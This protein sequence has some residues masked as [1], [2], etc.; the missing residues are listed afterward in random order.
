MDHAIE[1]AAYPVEVEVVEST[2]S[3]SEQIALIQHEAT[4]ENGLKTYY[5]MGLALRTIRDQRL[6]RDLYPSFEVYCQEKF[7]IVRQQ[8]YR[9]ISA[10]QVAEN[11]QGSGAI[12]QTESHAREL[13]SLPP[14]VQSEVWNKVQEAQTPVTAKVIQEVAASVA[15]WVAKPKQEPRPQ[16]EPQVLP[17]VVNDIYSPPP[18][19]QLQDHDLTPQLVIDL[20]LSVCGE[21]DLDPCSNSLETPRVPATAH[22]APPMDGVADNHIWVGNIYCYPPKDD[23]VQINRWVFRM[24]REVE[25][26]D[27]RN[28]FLYLPLVGI[29]HW[30]RPLVNYTFAV[31][32]DQAKPMV[33][34]YLGDRHEDFMAACQKENLYVLGRVE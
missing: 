14:H 28:G 15:P 19:Q 5:E 2:L 24:R 29:G 11:L 31:L 4:I 10:A 25:V 17:E 6:Y 34:V 9:L 32:G 8:A 12:P 3:G 30:L 22:Y 26:S 33:L 7:G 23:L 16:P 27:C 21:I 18:N 13:A 1:S 20:V